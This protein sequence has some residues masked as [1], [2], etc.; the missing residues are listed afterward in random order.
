MDMCTCFL[1]VKQ[2]TCDLKKLTLNYLNGI[3][4]WL[5][6]EDFLWINQ[7]DIFVLF[8]F[9]LLLYVPSQQLW[10]LRDGQFT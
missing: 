8:L 9:C 5:K 3:Q 2:L 7:F 1:P 10:S 6:T 4:Q